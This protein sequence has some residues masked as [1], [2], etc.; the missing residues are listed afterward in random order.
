MKVRNAC[1][2][3]SSAP[4]AAS[5]RRGGVFKASARRQVALVALVAGAVVLGAGGRA[6]RADIAAAYIQG[7][8]GLSSPQSSAAP[9]G[10]AL[11]PAASGDTAGGVGVQAG[12]RLLIFEGY[13]DYTAFGSGQS[14]LRGIVGLRG[15][16]GLGGFRLVLRGGGGLLDERGGVLTGRAADGTGNERIGVVARAGVALERQLAPLL[17]GGLGVDG[18]IFN[19]GSPNGTTIHTDGTSD[20][21]SGADIF[22]SLHLKFE[23]GI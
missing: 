5:V 18:E 22:L 1:A 2:A 12:A 13:G 19:L 14:V 6:A 7:Y 8:G 10:G 17:L 15:A 4:R 23:I 11:G 9:S 3:I 20:R 16:V 21:L